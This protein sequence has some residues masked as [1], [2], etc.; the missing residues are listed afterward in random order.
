MISSFSGQHRFL[1][2]FFYVQIEYEGEIYPSVE[3]AYQAAKTLDIKMRRRFRNISPAYSK[4]LG[5]QISLRSDWEDVKITVMTGLIR[6][7]FSWHN[8]KNGLLQTGNS[9]L[10]EGN[11]WGD[12]F[13]GQCPLGNGRNELGK[14][15]MQVRQELRVQGE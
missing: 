2:N 5:Q 15:L 7:K 10:V 4:K 1:S 12:R 8:L 14:I 11:Y 3:N 13:W 9:E 6:T